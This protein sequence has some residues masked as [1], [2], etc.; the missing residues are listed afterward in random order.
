MSPIRCS[1]LLCFVLS[2]SALAGVRASSDFSVDADGW[3]LQGDTTSSSPTYIATGGNPDGFLRGTDTVDGDFW[4]WSAPAKF[5]GPASSSYGETLTFDLRMRGSGP[6]EPQSDVILS[7]G[8]VTLALDLTP[9]PTDPAWTSYTALLSE[10]AGWRVNNLAGA[11]ATQQQM[12]TAL[13][14][15]TSLR[16]RGEFINGEDSGDI[17]NVVLNAVPEPASAGVLTLVICALSLRTRR[18]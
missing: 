12:M 11:L 9:T 4:Y 16:I 10:T 1:L 8:G 2:G 18:E 3:L 6:I 5:R 14:N 17:D 7:G 15:I 13:S